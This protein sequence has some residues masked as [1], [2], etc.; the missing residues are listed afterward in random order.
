MNRTYRILYSRND[1][2]KLEFREWLNGYPSFEV[3]NKELK[4]LQAK[5]Q[6]FIFKL[7]LE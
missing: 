6:D 7:E 4:K 3:A 5:N 2:A 1:K